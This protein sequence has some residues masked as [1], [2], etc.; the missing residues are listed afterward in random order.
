MTNEGVEPRERE[1]GGKGRQPWTVICQ[2]NSLNCI[3]KRDYQV[4]KAKIK[5]QKQNRMRSKP[6][7]HYYVVKFCRLE[8]DA[9]VGNRFVS[10]VPAPVCAA[11]CVSPARCTLSWKLLQCPLPIFHRHSCMLLGAACFTAFGFSPWGARNTFGHF[12]LA[13]V[14]PRCAEETGQSVQPE[15]PPWCKAVS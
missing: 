13:V 1:A 10:G 8:F 2:W 15:R 14:S 6:Q 5:K 12:F 3:Y 7:P 4:E 11:P 9:K